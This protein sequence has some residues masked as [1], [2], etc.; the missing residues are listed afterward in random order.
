[1][2]NRFG[3]VTGLSFG[4]CYFKRGVVGNRGKNHYLPEGSWISRCGNWKVEEYERKNIVFVEKLK[5]RQ[6]KICHSC[7]SL[8]SV[9]ETNLNL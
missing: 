1:M 2:F 3:V 8:Q 9:S 7:E 4:W 5:L 6:S